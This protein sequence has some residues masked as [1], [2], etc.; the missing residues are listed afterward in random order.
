VA[1]SGNRIEDV[2]QI[3]NRNLDRGLRS[4]T[5]EGFRWSA[6][7]TGNFGAI[8]LWLHYPDKGSIEIST[9]FVDAA[10]DLASLSKEENPLMRAVSIAPCVFSA[11]RRS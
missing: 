5:A 7:T 3:N 4:I 6:V 10:I 9:P 2:R 11:Y 1:V 8:D